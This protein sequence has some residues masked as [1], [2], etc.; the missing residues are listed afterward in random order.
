[1]TPRFLADENIDP[2]LVLGLRRR[3]ESV[4]IVRM[5]DVGLRTMDD[6]EILQWAAHEGRILISHDIKTMPGFAGERMAAGLP[7]HG[8]I[9]LHSTLPLAHALDELAAVAGASDAEEWNNQI[10]YLPLR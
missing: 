4:D 8:V 5:Q 6:P 9:L 1:M 10:A 3:V 2:D 7:M